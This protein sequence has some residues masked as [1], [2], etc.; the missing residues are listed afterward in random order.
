MDSNNHLNPDLS[1]RVFEIILHVILSAIDT[2][3]KIVGTIF[4]AIELTVVLVYTS[5]LL[6]RISKWSRGPVFHHL[7]TTF[8]CCLSKCSIY[9][10]TFNRASECT[11]LSLAA[12]TNLSTA[13]PF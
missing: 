1:I 9:I 8:W 12:Y 6:W 7:S 5:N 2:C 3:C 11:S 13:V 4:V 10:A